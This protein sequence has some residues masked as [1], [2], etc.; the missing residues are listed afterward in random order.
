MHLTV[1]E[2][3]WTGMDNKEREKHLQ[4]LGTSSR[5]CLQQEINEREPA[6][7][8]MVSFESSD[9]WFWMFSLLLIS[10]TTEAI[11]QYSNFSKSM[12]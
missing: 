12:C 6:S 8:Q 11:P 2:N 1:T 5:E 9:F 3:Q 10:S 7:E 4:K